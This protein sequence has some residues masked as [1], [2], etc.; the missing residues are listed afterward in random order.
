[1]SAASMKASA[2]CSDT[3]EL[4]Y[5][6]ISEIGRML[7]SGEVTSLDLT[8]YILARIDRLN[9]KFNAFITVTADLARE[10]ARKADAELG[11][12]HDRGALHGIPVAVKDILATQGIRTTSGSQLYGDHIP[13][14]DATV[15]ERLR[16]AGSVLLGK[17]GLYE[18]ASGVTGENPFFGAVDNPW[19]AGHDTGGSSSGSAS[20]VAAGLAFAAIGTD[21]GCSIRHPA[22]C[23]GIVGLKPTFGLV[24]KA[25]VQPLAWSLDHVGPL[26]RTAEDAAIV[27]QAIAGHDPTDPYSVHVPEMIF[28]PTTHPGLGGTKIAVIRRY[29]FECA[30]DILDRIEEAL[31]KMEELGAT[32]IE[33]DI[34]DLEEAFAAVEATFV[35]AAAIHEEALARH[36]EKFSDR[37]RRSL[38]ARLTTETVRYI[39]AQ[40]FREGFRG[41]VESLFSKVDVLIAPTSRFVPAPLSDL[42]DGYTRQVW[43]N[44]SIFNF[45]GHPSISVPCGFSSSGLP[46][47]MMITGRLHKDWELLQIAHS[48]EKAT[49]CYRMNPDV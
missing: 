20:A 10:Q 26:T 34:P 4:H 47:G 36:P 19:K 32:I 49:E 23:C 35:E 8:E 1:M 18:L 21:T 5:K 27:L 15:V 6:A 16:D 38:Q 45:T 2:G 17:T 12:G 25:G 3:L 28:Q 11:K 31:A 7:R 43:K 42:P 29:F 30:P 44:T 46:L 22:H 24:S 13:D 39:N 33:M 41:R 48:Y 40:H 9:T 14:H 37:V